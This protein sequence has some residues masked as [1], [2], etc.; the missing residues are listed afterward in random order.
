MMK[1][2]LGNDFTVACD[3]DESIKSLSALSN[4]SMTQVDTQTL[5]IMVRK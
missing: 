1:K 4:G 5:D 3:V 2:E